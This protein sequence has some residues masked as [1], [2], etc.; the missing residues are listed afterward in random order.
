MPIYQFRCPGGC[1]D[2]STGYPMADAPREDAC[3]QCAT[4]SRR[5]FGTPALGIGSTTAMRLQ[6]S[7][8]A[9]ADTPQVVNRLPGSAR[10]ATP[11]TTNP[12]HRRLPRP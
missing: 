12:L 5:L 10:R 8:R 6:D 9:S 3:P 1:P 2:F 7:T 4:P 11:V